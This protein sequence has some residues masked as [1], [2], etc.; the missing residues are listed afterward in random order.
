[1]KLGM[2]QAIIMDVWISEYLGAGYHSIFGT[3]TIAASEAPVCCTAAGIRLGG[4]TFLI[5]VQ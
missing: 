3:N 4:A 1:M 2:Q 5:H